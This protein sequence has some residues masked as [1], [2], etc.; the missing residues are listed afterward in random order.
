MLLSE[1][2]L[3][4]FKSFLDRNQKIPDP[5]T[6]LVAIV[7]QQP[8]LLLVEVSVPAAIPAREERVRQ[9]LTSAIERISISVITP[10]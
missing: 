4:P 10:E 3:S 1:L 6:F 8:Y 5:L 2:K 7:L 9:D